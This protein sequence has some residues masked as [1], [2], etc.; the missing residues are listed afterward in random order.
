MKVTTKYCNSSDQD[1]HM[2][3]QCVSLALQ[4]AFANGHVQLAAFFTEHITLAQ[5]EYLGKQNT[6]FNL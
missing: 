4:W 6:L 3:N 5:F 2:P 1:A